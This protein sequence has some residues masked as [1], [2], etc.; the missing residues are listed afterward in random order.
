MSLRKPTELPEL[1]MPTVDDVLIPCQ[2]S[3]KFSKLLT[4]GQIDEAYSLFVQEFNRLLHAIPQS[5]KQT[6]PLKT[7]R[8]KVPFHDQRRFPK[9]IGAHAS[10]LNSRKLYKA[11]YQAVEVSKASPGHRADT[12]WEAMLKVSHLILPD[13]QVIFNEIMDIM[14][15]PASHD[16]ALVISQII[17]KSMDA[18]FRH[19]NA[20]RLQKW[21]IRMRTDQSQNYK[22]LKSKAKKA[23]VTCPTTTLSTSGIKPSSPG[24]DS[25]AP[26]EI[27]LVAAWCPEILTILARL[28]NAIEST[29]RWPQDLS[30][31]AV[32]F[33]PKISGD[34][35]S[36]TDYRPLTNLSSIYR[37]WAAT[38]QDQLCE[39]W[40]PH[41]QI[42][43]IFLHTALNK[44]PRLRVCPKHATRTI[45]RR[46][47]V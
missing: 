19:D 41:W 25:I 29:G 30:K 34:N 5:Q 23:A 26:Q 28:C 37:L 40:L 18:M 27:Q 42:I 2:I 20:Q 39:Q 3:S 13:Q 21:T 43:Y 15:R 32:C 17:Q 22:W 10:T 31:G 44:Q 47:V 6:Y 9:A 24:M 16:D 33:L 4:Q 7:C 11:F 35:L 14:A 38:G 8:G 36:P 12:T 1:Q 45:C 46:F